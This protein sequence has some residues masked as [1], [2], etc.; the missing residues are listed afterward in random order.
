[1]NE[2]YFGTTKNIVDSLR[3]IVPASEEEKRR[4]LVQEVHT[5]LQNKSQL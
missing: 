4:R 3:S 1:M 5:A 2:V